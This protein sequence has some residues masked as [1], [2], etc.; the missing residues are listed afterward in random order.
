MR[1]K[2]VAAV[3]FLL[4][5]LASHAAELTRA[6]LQHAGRL[7]EAGLASRLAYQLVASLTT[8]VGSRAAGS[9]GDARAVAWAVD[10]LQRLGFASVRADPVPMKA[11]RRGPAQAQVTAP[12]EQPL[13]ILALG[14]SVATP[15]AGIE[16]EVAYYPDLAA[17]QAET[18][19]RARGRIVFIDQKTERTRDGSGYGSAVAARSTGAVEAAKRGAV[20]LA[21]RSIGTDRNR[22]AHTGGMRYDA[23]VPRIPAV[24]V[25][26]PDAD[27]VA[28]MAAHPATA[29]RPLRMHLKVHTESDVAITTHNVIAEIPGTDLAGEIVLLG[30]HLDSWDV[31]TGAI[32]DAA[33]VGIVT[34]AAKV[35]LDGG[36]KPRRTIRV[37]LFGNEENGLDGAR[38]YG[39]RYKD[40]PHQLVAESDFGAGKVWRFSSRVLPEALPEV[41]R[42]ATVLQPLGIAA[43]D[44]EGR[45]APDAAVLMGTQRWPAFDL[46]QDG[47][48]YFDWHHTNNDTLDKVDATSLPQNIAGWA[49][50][51]WLAAQSP[52]AFGPLPATP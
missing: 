45:P 2:T 24:A 35:I 18:G 48:D 8:E 10:Q 6:D 34:A 19:D 51:A 14:N 4:A 1:W 12:F 27:L 17:L 11:W 7:R 29:A 32:D 43:G 3:A 5:S 36:R 39:E 52:V 49:V 38:A 9:P 37:V 31:G 23:A 26:I 15:P 25:S 22:L 44:N 50:A 41:A 16:A 40:Q 13:E 33:G 47:T 30:A 20:A 28:R 46:R 21:I 42:I